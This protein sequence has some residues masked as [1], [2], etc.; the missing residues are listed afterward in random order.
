LSRELQSVALST[1]LSFFSFAENIPFP[2]FIGSEKRECIQSG[3]LQFMSEYNLIVLEDDSASC[4]VEIGTIFFRFFCK[5]NYL[6]R[7]YV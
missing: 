7:I 6:E 4:D 5:V 2:Y 1:R 3:G